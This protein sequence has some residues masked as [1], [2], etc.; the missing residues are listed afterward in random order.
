[1]RQIRRP[2]STALL[3]S[4]IPIRL[5]FVSALVRILASSAP[6]HGIRKESPISSFFNVEMIIG[7]LERLITGG[8][9]AFLSILIFIILWVNESEKLEDEVSHHGGRSNHD[10]PNQNQA[11]QVRR[12]VARTSS[13]VAMVAGRW[14]VFAGPAVK[15]A[16]LVAQD[17]LTA[18]CGLSEGGH[19]GGWERLER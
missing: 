5:Q 4:V 2:P 11:T 9:G 1:M 17:S 12:L 8:G 19:A 13:I 7:Q 10:D 3:V 16:R 18:R 6:L 15:V 14:L